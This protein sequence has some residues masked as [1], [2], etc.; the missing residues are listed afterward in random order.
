MD[1]HLI[2]DLSCRFFFAL[3]VDSQG[4]SS[5]SS[6]EI[7]DKSSR[8]FMTD[9]YLDSKF[10]DSKPDAGWLAGV[11]RQI[12]S[13]QDDFFFHGETIGLNRA[14][15]IKKDE[16]Y[17]RLTDLLQLL[18]KPDLTREIALVAYPLLAFLLQPIIQSVLDQGYKVQELNAIVIVPGYLSPQAYTIISKLFKAHKEYHF[19]KVRIINQAVALA[20]HYIPSF[21]SHRHIIALHEDENCL[22]VSKLVVE[23]TN[24][25]IKVHY[26]DCHSVKAYG[27][28]SLNKKL[29]DT[30]HNDELV[31]LRNGRVSVD[32]LERALSG[33]FTGILTTEI[34]TQPPLKLTYPL[35]IE[36]V[37]KFFEQGDT[38]KIIDSLPP[39]FLN[40]S[41]FQIV[42]SGTY[43]LIAKYEE[44]LL[45]AL[46]KNQTFEVERIP[47]MERAAY[48]VAR[49]LGMRREKEIHRIN[50][51][52]KY[53]IRVAG[54]DGCTIELIPANAFLFETGQEKD[55]KQV[56]ALDAEPAMKED[57]LAIH[58]LWGNNPIAEYNTCISTILF[59]VTQDDIYNNKIE[60]DFHF[61][62]IANKLTG[63]V[64][65]TM[66]GRDSQIKKLNFPRFEALPQE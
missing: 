58:I 4:H 64:T 62:K 16:E 13:F 55:I 23:R 15:A 61:K 57:M 17:L 53:S 25:N 31:P 10:K 22:H 6:Y 24:A 39:A 29:L 33:Y 9:I 3:L 48:G 56:L 14:H 51:K 52:N 18:S 54:P 36:K 26:Q 60:L 37:K 8:Y 49:M 46:D 7:G 30:L 27:R 5:P 44:L 21:D 63:N 40:G 66:K 1:P 45:N 34:P 35:L 50:E 20:M 59:D 43:F 42:A 47:A 11:N 32:V 12:K 41:H 19:K 65:A 28:R 38:E 2:I